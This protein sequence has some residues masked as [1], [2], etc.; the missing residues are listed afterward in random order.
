MKG[1]RQ[2]KY[3]TL[4][5]RADQMLDIA[6]AKCRNNNPKDLRFVYRIDG[7]D[8]LTSEGMRIVQAKEL[9]AENAFLYQI[10]ASVDCLLE[11]NERDDNEEISEKLYDHLVYVNFGSVFSGYDSEGI[12]P[13][14]A[15][16]RW[17]Y[18]DIL[19]PAVESLFQNGFLLEKNN[20]DTGETEYIHFLPFDK[21]SSMARKSMMTFIDERI[22]KHVH[23]KFCMDLDFKITQKELSKYYAYRGLYL[24]DAV[25]IPE[26]DK[27]FILNEETVIVI[28]DKRVE[29]KKQHIMKTFDT[30]S[31]IG[32]NIDHGDLGGLAV[33]NTNRV[34]THFDGEGFISPQY[35]QYLN[36]FLYGTEK[37]ATS[38]QIRMPFVKG[39]LHKVDFHRFVSEFFDNE[40]ISGDSHDDVC[41]V[42]EM[43]NLTVLDVFGKRRKIMDAQIILTESMF[44]CCRW[45]MKKRNNAQEAGLDEDELALYFCGFHKYD[46][47]FYV[48]K[49]DV[50]YNNNQEYNT[51]LNYQFLNTLGLKQAEMKKLVNQHAEKAGKLFQ[52]SNEMIK[53]PFIYN[54]LRRQE[55][56]LIQAIGLGRI[57][58]QGTI[59]LLSEDLLELLLYI[60]EIII[61]RTG[62]KNIPKKWKEARLKFYNAQTIFRR[63]FFCADYKNMY[64]KSAS[65]YAIL[66][67]PHLSRNEDCVMNPYIPKSED[68]V[69]VRYFADLKNVIMTPFYSDVPMALGGA[70]FDGDTV[71]IIFEPLVSRAILRNTYERKLSSQDSSHIKGYYEK[72]KEYPLVQ[73]GAPV[74]KRSE[75][76]TKNKIENRRVELDA[77]VSSEVI[78]NT[79]ANQIGK[80]SNYAVRQGEKAYQGKNADAMLALKCAAS[81][82]ATGLEID[83]AKNGRHPDIEKFLQN[84]Y[85]YQPWAKTEGPALENAETEKSELEDTATECSEKRYLLTETQREQEKASKKSDYLE[86]YSKIRELDIYHLDSYYVKEKKGELSLFFKD[87]RN[88]K[89]QKVTEV[90]ISKKSEETFGFKLEDL[91]YYF[92]EKFQNLHEKGEPKLSSDIRC[93]R[94]QEDENWDS[95]LKNQ[96][97]MDPKCEE[98]M[99]RLTELIQAYKNWKFNQMKLNRT[100][101]RSSSQSQT[102][103]KYVHTLLTMEYDYAVDVVTEQK[104]PIESALDFTYMDL[105]KIF[106]TVEEIDEAINRMI[107]WN[108]VFTTPSNREKVFAQI[109]GKPYELS[110]A[111][112]AIL[113]DNYENSYRYLEYILKDIREMMLTESAW[114]RIQGHETAVS[115]KLT[116]DYRMAIMNHEKTAD[117]QN[118]VIKF[119]RNELIKI[120]GDIKA[121][122]PYAFYFR[123]H[124][125]QKTNDFSGTFFWT[126]FTNDDLKELFYDKNLPIP[127]N[128]GDFRSENVE[129]D[130]TEE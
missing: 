25:R 79:F 83:A 129:I 34:V 11:S 101:N 55:L 107:E 12:Y 97:K 63:R 23:Q 7:F 35:A 80:I 73:I 90:G 118:K 68:D 60:C 51:S 93:F 130:E 120:F 27:Q 76:N 104:I 110:E 46:H 71:K 98:R 62:N 84:K 2:K 96:I 8:R 91:V 87:S 20:S 5:L 33:E 103:Y 123:L 108:W 4:T 24:T 18:R 113:F 105:Q 32:D 21:S 124:S 17:R 70:D 52:E 56:S 59:K 14:H 85:Q 128:A 126:I 36:S 9:R 38:F 116:E 102:Y 78:Y 40:W 54:D 53:D 26:D 29:L 112:R 119:C 13:V 74:K 43:E 45:M 15:V 81:T 58:V 99:N 31:I 1:I 49:T 86:L 30:Q 125:Y 22:I 114:E 121:A 65:H 16:E 77:P 28:P 41:R 122:V 115:R 64:L 69:Y 72:K 111:S 106:D 19:K 3:K 48:A 67:S 82:I 50:A 117:F 66:R 61:E 44:K 6:M 57:E 100:K 127:E 95:Q 94:F 10:C 47:G 37:K 88:G 75:K 92:L 89:K 42:Q 39:M 109:I